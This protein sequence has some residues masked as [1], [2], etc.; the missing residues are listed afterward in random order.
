MKKWTKITL[1]VIGVA[2][3]GGVVLKKMGVIG[4]EKLKEVVV[5]KVVKGSIIQTVNGSGKIYPEV[6]VKISPDVS[7][8]LI[9]LNVKEGDSVRKGQVLGRIY[10]ELLELQR[11]QASAQ[12]NQAQAGVGN[13][14]AGIGAISARLE[15]ARRN[16][17]TNKALYDEKVISRLELDQ[18]STT[19]QTIEAEYN[20]ALKGIQANQASVASASTGLQQAN[21]NLNR[22]TIYATMDGVVSVLN[23]KKGERVVGTA[24]MAGTEILRIADM[25]TLETVIDVSENDIPKVKVGDTADIEIDAYVGR[26]FYGIV[27]QIGS[28]SSNL[29]GNVGQVNDVTNYKVKIR[30]NQNSYNDLIV[31]GRSFPLR[32]G[33]T[34]NVKIKTQT[35]QNVLTIPLT[36]L[37][38]RIPTDSASKFKNIKDDDIVLFSYDAATKKVKKI[39]VTPGIQDLD[40]IEILSGVE[41]GVDIVV[42]PFIIISKELEDD[43]KVES[44]SREKLLGKKET[45]KK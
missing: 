37:T 12:V 5:E 14:S 26:K 9:E 28:S 24:Q 31:A 6:E 39:K 43:M 4:K 36:A 45:D 41:E 35:K 44:V 7:G 25:R 20:A 3:V 22:T 23:N 11:Q 30:V 42:E 18:Y 40:N 19:L 1:G 2:I 32:P 17:T 15:Q 16:Y 10:G 27:T 13:S 21:K 38:S 29:S 8:E 33:M 34:T